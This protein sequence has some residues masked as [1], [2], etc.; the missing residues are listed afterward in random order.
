MEEASYLIPQKRF[1]SVPKQHPA[2]RHP[3]REM[4]MASGNASAKWSK[5]G[6][7]KPNTF[8]ASSKPEVN[9]RIPPRIVIL[10]DGGR[11]SCV[12]NSTH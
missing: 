12:N 8:F 4:A 1:V 9:P 3:T 10:V 7:L 6:C 2:I 5:T 11:W